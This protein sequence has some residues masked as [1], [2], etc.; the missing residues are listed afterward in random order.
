MSKITRRL[1]MNESGDRIIFRKAWGATL[2]TLNYDV[3]A[4]FIISKPWN[5]HVYEKNLVMPWGVRSA[6]TSE[7]HPSH[8]LDHGETCFRC[9]CAS[10]I[11]WRA[12]YAYLC[13]KYPFIGAKRCKVTRQ[14][15]HPQALESDLDPHISQDI[16][17]HH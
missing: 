12:V 1:A 3:L 5:S 8:T 4:T 16:F 14:V 13:E 10:P 11:G 17:Q 7:D 15:T 9:Y 6:Q 2:L